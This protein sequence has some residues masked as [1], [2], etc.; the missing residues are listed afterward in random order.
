[1]LFYAVL[2]WLTWLAWRKQVRLKQLV[3]IPLVPQTHKTFLSESIEWNSQIV[4]WNLIGRLIGKCLVMDYQWLQSVAFT[5]MRV[6]NFAHKI[7]YKCRAMES[8]NESMCMFT[9]WEVLLCW[10]LKMY[11]LTSWP[12]WYYGSFKLQKT[13]FFQIAW[14][15]NWAA[16]IQY[17]YTIQI[18]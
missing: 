15:K 4:T 3:W 13:C 9:A 2:C 14:N 1:M 8:R 7:F 16:S 11:L 17:I 18:Y 6:R 10:F 5:L 12:V